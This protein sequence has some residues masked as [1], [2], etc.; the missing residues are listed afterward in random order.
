LL[1][2]PADEWRQ[3]FSSGRRNIHIEER[4]PRK[5]FSS[6]QTKYSCVGAQTSVSKVREQFQH[7]VLLMVQA[8]ALGW[9]RLWRDSL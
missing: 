5:P 7:S 1:S 8:N 3:E 2:Y 6:I 9:N 4:P